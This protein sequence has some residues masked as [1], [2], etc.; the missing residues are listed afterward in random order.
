MVYLIYMYMLYVHANN[1]HTIYR[2][3]AIDHEF[4]CPYSKHPSLRVWD[5]MVGFKVATD[6]IFGILSKPQL[7]DC[8]DYKNQYIMVRM[9]N[10]GW[11]LITWDE[12]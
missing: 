9:E 12:Y 3:F 11:L 8:R 2:I 1:V 7:V 6:Q 4:I 5:G 10:N